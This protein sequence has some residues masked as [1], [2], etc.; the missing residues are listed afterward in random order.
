MNNSPTIKKVKAIFFLILGLVV[1]LVLNRFSFVFSQTKSVGIQKIFDTIT[2]SLQSLNSNP[3]FISFDMIPLLAFLLGLIVIGLLYLLSTGNSK[4]R[5]G[6]E[7]GSARWATKG[8]LK[9]FA[10]TKN[11]D[12]NIILSQDVRMNM[13]TKNVPFDYQRNKNVL[14]VSGAGGG[15][16]RLFVKPNLSQLHSTYI[17]TDPKG[18]L[19][20]ETGKMMEEHGYEVKVFDINSFTNSN[21]FNPFKYVTNE[22]TLKRII[23]VII[24]ST[25]GEN[26]RKG[27]PFWD[28]S[29]E[30]LL[31]ALFSYLYY[32]YKGD[33]NN[34]G[35][36]VLP[37]LY[38]VSDLIRQAQ[39]VDEKVPSVLE[40][41]FE[42]FEN[43]FG[44]DNYAVLLFKSFSNY[45]GETRSSVL[46]ISTARF[47]MFD[48]RDIKG[49]IEDD[50]LEIDTWGTKKTV[51]Y[52]PIP[53]IDTT[54]NFLTTMIFVLAFRTLEFQADNVYGGKLPIHTRFILDEFANLGKIPNIKEALSVFR[55]REISIDIILQSINQIKALYKDDWQSLLGNCDSLVYLAGPTEKETVKFFSERAG[56]ETIEMK[57]NSESKGVNG[58]YSISHDVLGR[59]LITESEVFELP[60]SECLVSISSKPLYRGKKY[61]A[62]KHPRYKE[63]ADSPDDKNWYEFK[64]KLLSLDEQFDYYKKIVPISI[65]E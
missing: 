57:K 21:H 1:G 40:L 20:H 48:L 35:D 31:G 60:R 28:K 39:R 37:T 22:Q 13:T 64:P 26:N 49:M 2:K 43:K 6:R 47:S 41:L 34:E 18:L 53:D 11:D 5:K 27:D 3:L 30:L 25:N 50:D 12:N 46:A 55:S 23:Q 9:K 61:Q 15:K 19:L 36:G 32:C 51:V 17:V 14:V 42:D 16:T 45:Q 65:E 59:E 33:E 38:N 58:S 54:F 63:W 8:E 44:E 24:D 62:E 29:E 52:L 7:Y 4:Y 56:K 10:D